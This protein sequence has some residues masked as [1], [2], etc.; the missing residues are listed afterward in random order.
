[1]SESAPPAVAKALETARGDLTHEASRTASEL[2]DVDHEIEKLG[3]AID[4]LVQQ[5]QTL[6][7][8]RARLTVQRGELQ[9]RSRDVAHVALY[10]ALEAQAVAVHG[11]GDAWAIQTAD[12][13][14]PPATPPPEVQAVLDE[15]ANSRAALLAAPTPPPDAEAHHEQVRERL[16]SVLAEQAAPAPFDGAELSVDV[17]WCVDAPESTPEL[18]VVLLPVRAW[19]DDPAQARDALPLWLAARV[20]QVVFAAARAVDF[21]EIDVR[22]GPALGH[23]LLDIE[24]DLAGAPDTVLAEVR[25]RLTEQLPSAPEFAAG[26]VSLQATELDPAIVFPAD[27]EETLHG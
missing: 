5:R 21:A 16:R 4:N 23:D 22:T 25:Q 26:R 20:G 19:V 27:P 3:K 17:V 18:L 6:E 24:V 10:E 13:L 9:R 8:Y 12:R 15:L 1:M 14:A 2:V 7:Q 11:R